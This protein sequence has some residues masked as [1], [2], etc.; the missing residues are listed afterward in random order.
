MDAIRMLLENALESQRNEEFDSDKLH[1]HFADHHSDMMVLHH[2]KDAMRLFPKA[3]THM[4]D[5]YN[6]HLENAAKTHAEFH[7]YVTKFPKESADEG[8]LKVHNFV[9]AIKHSEDAYHAG[10]EAAADR[11]LDAEHEVHLDSYQ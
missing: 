2:M 7:N 9:D 6:D 4:E 8:F 11:Q 5:D 1:G 10:Q 3:R